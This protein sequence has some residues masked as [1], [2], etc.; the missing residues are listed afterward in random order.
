LT[1]NGKDIYAPSWFTK[2]FPSFELDGEL[3]TKRKDF[4][5]ISSIVRGSLYPENWERVTYNIFEVPNVKGGLF[6]RL[7]KVK[8]YK[9]KILKIIPQIKVKNKANLQKFLKE[10]EAKGGEGVVVH[11]PNSPYIAKRTSKA[12]KVKSF[13]DTECKVTRYIKGHGKF[14]GML[15][16]LECRLDNGTLFKIGSG[17]TNQE[18]KNPPPI[19]SI[20]TFKYKE[21]TKYGKPRFPVFM[22]IR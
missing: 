5:N 10:I 4:E 20:I 6:E 19:G 14:K 9:S 22:R 7:S 13:Y 8:P 12:L 1:R 16:S 17:F 2:G 11:D 15:G 3:W 21:F 18:R